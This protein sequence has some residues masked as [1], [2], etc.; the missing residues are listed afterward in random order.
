MNTIILAEYGEFDG[1]GSVQEQRAFT[2]LSAFLAAKP[3]EYR[4]GAIGE[5]FNGLWYRKDTNQWVRI[6]RIPL[7]SPECECGLRTRLV[8]D[9]CA[10]CNPQRVKDLSD[11]EVVEQ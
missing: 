5:P 8:G 9:G 3:K 10:V 7:D 1:T 11:R 2:S 6:R 4:T